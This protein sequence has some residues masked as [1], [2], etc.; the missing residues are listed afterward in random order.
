[1]RRVQALERL[2]DP[3]RGGS[4]PTAQFYELLLEAGFPEKDAL[5]AAKQRG[6]DRLAA[7]QVM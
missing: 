6:W 5:E 7:E 4:L 1:M 3:E 2:Q